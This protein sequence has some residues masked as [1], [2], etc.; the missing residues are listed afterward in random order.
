MNGYKWNTGIAIDLPSSVVRSSLG[1]FNWDDAI[2]QCNRPYHCIVILVVILWISSSHKKICIYI[3]RCT[4]LLC[5]SDHA[6][7]APQLLLWIITCRCMIRYTYIIIYQWYF[8]R[9][10]VYASWKLYIQDIHR[11]QPWITFPSPFCVAV[12]GRSIISPSF[13][14]I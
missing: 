12:V 10:K 9:H 1:D 4:I 2:L 3:Y 5:M 13:K 6:I 14:C 7:A 11:G 8:R